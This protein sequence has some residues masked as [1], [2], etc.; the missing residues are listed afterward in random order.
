MRALIG[1]KRGFV[2]VGTIS[3]AIIG[4]SVIAGYF[5][6]SLNE[7]KLSQCTFKLQAAM[8]LAEVGL[9]LGMAQRRRKR[10]P[11]RHERCSRLCSFRRQVEG[12]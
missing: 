2:L 5:T 1:N 11:A 4:A 7:Y 8:N 10:Q 3:I 6:M 12:F 9:E